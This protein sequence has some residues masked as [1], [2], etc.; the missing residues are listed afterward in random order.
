MRYLAHDQSFESFLDD[1]NAAAGS[2]PVPALGEGRFVSAQ[3]LGLP[4]SGTTIALQL[5]AATGAVGYPS[6]VMAFFH[7][8][9]W[10]G[11]RLQ[12]QLAAARPAISFT[13]VAGR[14]AEPLDPHEMGYFWRRVCGHSANSLVRDLP[15][16]PVAEVQHQLDLVAAVFEAPVVYKNFLAIQHA[17]EMRATWER[18]RFIVVRRDVRDVAAS[19]LTVRRRLGVAAD[20]PFGVQP[21]TDPAVGADE[22]RTVADQVIALEEAIEAND[23]AAHDDACVVTYTDLS[24]DPRGQV[25]RL[26]SFLGAGPVRDPGALPATLPAG[27]G[28]AALDPTDQRR[29]AEALDTALAGR[30][31]R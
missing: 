6:N 18:A 1:L 27:A 14:T 15:P 22:F 31:G 19:L 3:M 12:R 29:L 10:V 30:E 17:T 21:V 9:P 2:M 16:E 23:F 7:R 5:L 11:A 20:A 24:Q 8:A 25:E 4:R 26:L 13:S 28:F